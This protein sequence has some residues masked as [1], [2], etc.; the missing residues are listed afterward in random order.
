ME[1][2]EKRIRDREA[3]F[4]FMVR[5]PSYGEKSTQYKSNGAG[6]SGHGGYAPNLEEGI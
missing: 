5:Y 4:L 3:G 6:I 2:N 1:K